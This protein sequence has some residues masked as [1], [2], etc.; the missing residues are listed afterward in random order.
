MACNLYFE[1][2]N[3]QW[4]I[5]VERVTGIEPAWPVWKT[6]TLPLS[7]TR[8]LHGYYRA[9]AACQSAPATCLTHFRV[10][11]PKRLQIS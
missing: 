8:S 3:P 9:T 11:R 1:T 2:I 7:Y 10:P 5:E 4:F 6:G